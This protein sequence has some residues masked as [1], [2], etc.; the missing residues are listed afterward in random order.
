[1]TTLIT[2]DLWIGLISRVALR[3]NMVWIVRLTH[4]MLR[5]SSA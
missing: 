4:P 1:M 3:A 2:P 5:A